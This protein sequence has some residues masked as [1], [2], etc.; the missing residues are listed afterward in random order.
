LI[1]SVLSKRFLTV[2]AAILIEA[3][4]IV[5]LIL[6]DLGDRV[7][8]FLVIYGI[9]FAGYVLAISC[10]EALSYRSVIIWGMLFRLTVVFAE[11]SLSDDAFRYLWDGLVQLESIN[12]YAFAPG[13][14][15]LS[16]V[17]RPDILQKVNHPELPTIY[18]PFAQL[19]FRL[20]ALIAPEVWVVKLGLVMWDCLAVVFLAGLARSYDIHPA[21]VALYFWNP[22]LVLEGAGQGHIDVMAVSLLAA[23]LLYVRIGGYGRA[24]GTLALA[25]LVK[26]LPLLLVPAFW[27]WCAQRESDEK[28]TLSAMFTTRAVLIPVVFVGVFTGLYLPFREMGWEAFGSLFTYASSWEFNAPFYSLLRG[29]GLTGDSTRLILGAALLVL[30]V[31]V[32][33]RSMPPI[34]AA[35]YLMG[36]FLIL[37]PT[38]YP[39]YVIWILPFLCFYGNRGWLVLSGFVVISYLILIRL[40]EHG[41]WVEDEWVKWAIFAGSAAVWM[42][43]RLVSVFRKKRGASP[44]GGPPELSANSGQL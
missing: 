13:A 15:E 7:P 2:A 26:F 11:P 35:Y 42:T 3:C 33:V 12:P 25:S 30:T 23:A 29:L 14:S 17:A 37:T 16:G 6:G 34:Q 22:L 41:V 24:G 9:A 40:R 39:W 19:F 38:L 36:G 1:D 27:R 31:G 4:W 32:S 10:I 20:C 8:A 18:P 5:L 21:A 28:S 44:A 43:P